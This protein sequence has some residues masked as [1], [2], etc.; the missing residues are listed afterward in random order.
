M[1]P[2]YIQLTRRLRAATQATFRVGYPH[3]KFKRFV[4]DAPTARSDN[5][6]VFDTEFAL[7]SVKDGNATVQ[8]GDGAPFQLT[9]GI[10]RTTS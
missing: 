7:L 9:T 6:T 5:G 10:S 1:T 3:H 4:V 2:T 8:V